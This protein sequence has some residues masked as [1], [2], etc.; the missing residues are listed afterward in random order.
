MVREG[1]RA[2]RGVHLVERVARLA[3]DCEAAIADDVVVVAAA[4]HARGLADEEASVA[5]VAEILADEPAGR[6]PLIVRRLRGDAF[7]LTPAETDALLDAFDPVQDAF[8]RT[9]PAGRQNSLSYTLVARELVQRMDPNHWLLPAL[10]VASAPRSRLSLAQRD[11]IWRGVCAD[12]EGQ[13]DLG[14][15]V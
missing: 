9:A 14:Q 13:A 12:L 10:R 15:V 1:I 8:E 4:L 7:S 3:A 6:A 11:A 5:L 2:R